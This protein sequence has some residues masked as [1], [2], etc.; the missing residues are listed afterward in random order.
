M[1]LLERTL[2]TMR[3]WRTSPNPILMRELRQDARL[4]R[5]PW[6]VMG[7]TMLLALMI[8]SMG[9]QRSG[10]PPEEIGMMVFQ[11]F[12]VLAYFAL[13][14][15]GPAISANSIAAERE[16][17]TWEA[18]LLTGMTARQIT[19]GKFLSAAT[20]VGVYVV[21]AAPVSALAFLFGGVH[22][23]EVL[24]A[25]FYLFCAAMLS[26]SFGLA[27]SSRMTQSRGAIV[28]TLVCAFPLSGIAFA[29]FGP[30][31]GQGVHE[32]WPQVPSSAPFWLPLA[33]VRGEFGLTYLLVLVL[34]PLITFGAP[35]WGFYEATLANLTEPTDDRS[36][37]LKV[38][39]TGL[40]V[41]GAVA[42]VGL[43]GT[44]AR[45]SATTSQSAILPMLATG[46]LAIFG[47]LVLLADPLGASMR[48]QRRWELANAGRLHRW[49][50]PGLVRTMKL[51]LFASL[52][53][54]G[55]LLAAAYVLG[56]VLT[57]PVGDDALVVGCYC[58]GF[59]TFIVGLAVAL[60]SRSNNATSVRLIIGIIFIAICA[61]PPIAAFLVS[62]VFFRGSDE[63]WVVAAPSPFYMAAFARG[64][65]TAI[66]VAGW[67]ATFSWA[68]IGIFLF[69]VG[70]NRI[71]AVIADFES[72]LKATDRMFK[73][74][75][76][77]AQA[78]EE[79][80]TEQARGLESGSE[81]G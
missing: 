38:W 2:A 81:P 26:V 30:A 62:V 43:L 27:V 75:D 64:G 52:G 51:V 48:V 50:G 36:T 3:G 47:V 19:R 77:L 68:A 61:I 28:L 6:L 21:A 63:G 5:T 29:V 59:I 71:E 67:A 34:A 42:G 25:F 14:I 79:P 22:W 60:R 35:L 33:Y 72:R 66:E 17:R 46:F 20:S 18:M 9:S 54:L 23:S 16:G 13:A 73:E 32:L 53:L 65:S 1:S 41:A 24:I 8:A 44:T 12:F 70:Q 11:T 15:V 56:A 37:G 74:E 10:A 31:I 58:A 45:A 78:A 7:S 76:A 4:V 80:P 69:R 49:F 39:F 40:C 55:V 57:I